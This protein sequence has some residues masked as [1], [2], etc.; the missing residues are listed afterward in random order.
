MAAGQVVFLASIEWSAAWQ[1]HQ[2]LASQF[3]EAGWEVYFVENTGFRDF[4]P[5]DAARVIRRAKRAAAPPSTPHPGVILV[6]PM[7]LPP[8]A[9]AFRAINRAV[10]VPR[11]SSRLRELGL[12]DGALV[13]AYLP[14]ATTLALLD[15]LMPSQVVYDCVDNFAGH[16][17]PPKDLKETE[18]RLLAR[19]S[20]VLATSPFLREKH[21]AQHP[22]VQELHHGVE[23]RFFSAGGQAPAQYRKFCYFGSLWHA[24]DYR[25]A[26]ALAD[27]GFDVTLL[28]PVRELLPKLP[29]G[30]RHL[31]PVA[32]ADLPAA[33]APYDALLLP[34]ADTPYNTGVVPAKTFECLAT[35]KPVIASPIGGLS[36]YKDHFYLSADPAEW[37][38]IAKKLPNTESAARRE[39]RVAVARAH[40]TPEQF[41]KL[42]A[43]INAR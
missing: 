4:K 11:I 39:A 14:T 36:D 34:Y 29:R 25:Y 37:V 27:A 15:R 24:L 30:V 10:L 42:L 2:A 16:P 32:G 26:A 20:H 3:A 7:V 1:R 40:T 33:L 13:V 6:S 23:E 5:A 12:R 35:G 19:A 21:A 8:T 9:R 38:E 17:A 18:A 31:P 43:I 41:R 22:R 28:G